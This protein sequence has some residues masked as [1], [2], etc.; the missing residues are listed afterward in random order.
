MND[1][2]FPLLLC[3]FQVNDKDGGFR[4]KTPACAFSFTLRR[5][6][7]IANIQRWRRQQKRQSARAIG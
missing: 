5:S 3:Q 1:S 2:I 7:V 6:F 4:Q